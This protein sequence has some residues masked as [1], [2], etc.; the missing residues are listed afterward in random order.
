MKL[1]HGTSLKH[2]EAILR[3][4]ILPR[5]TKPSVWEEYPSRNDCVYLTAAYPLFFAACAIDD[6]KTEKLAVFEIETDK[7]VQSR[8]LPDEDCVAQALQDKS[9]RGEKAFQK[10][11][12]EVQARLEE[13][14][15]LWKDSIEH[16][17]NCC[18]RGPITPQAITRY[19]VLDLSQ[20]FWLYDSMLGPM[21]T[22]MNYKVMG[23]FYRQFV[24]WV[25]GDQAE[26]PQVARSKNILDAYAMDGKA[27][28]EISE[29]HKKTFDFWTKNSKDRSGIE[30]FNSA[31]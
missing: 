14:A 29:H 12:F 27:S 1:Y 21:I 11:H 3:D 5:E 6:R 28:D 17:G 22:F 30:V 8:F 19:A 16:L 24:A 31:V 18:Y 20:R 13:W 10:L 2:V 9:T 23:D 25:F 4:G 7:L 15:P 26:L